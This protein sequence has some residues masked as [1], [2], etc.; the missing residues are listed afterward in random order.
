MPSSSF[1]FLIP[2]TSSEMGNSLGEPGAPPL[3]ESDGA[4][5]YAS[6]YRARVSKYQNKTFERIITY[7]PK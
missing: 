7:L 3:I 2:E 6:P 4:N 5:L 1:A